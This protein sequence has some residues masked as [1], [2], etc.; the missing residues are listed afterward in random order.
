MENHSINEYDPNEFAHKHN[1]EE[2]PKAGRCLHLWVMM[3]ANKFKIC[4]I[5]I[6]LLGARVHGENGFLKG[7]ME[8]NG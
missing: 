7:W 3:M 6:Q 4:L 5:A 1:T 2:K 8:C